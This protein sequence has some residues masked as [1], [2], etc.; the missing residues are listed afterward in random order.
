MSD[1][2]EDVR[3]IAEALVLE[4]LPPRDVRDASID[5]FDMAGL[6]ESVRYLIAVAINNERQRCAKWAASCKSSQACGY[7]AEN[8]EEW[9]LSGDVA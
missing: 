1:I 4:W 5:S 9:I 2:P 6:Q 7:M 8:I 3:K